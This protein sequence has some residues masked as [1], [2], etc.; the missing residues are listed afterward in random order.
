MRQ[1]TENGNII[2]LYSIFFE[3]ITFSL[4]SQKERKF[5]LSFIAFDE[6]T[7]SSQ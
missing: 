4:S 1:K 6:L 2:L 7:K 5:V 3:Q